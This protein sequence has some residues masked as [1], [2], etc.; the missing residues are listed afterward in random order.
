[1]YL[2]KLV[3]HRYQSTVATV[4][5]RTRAARAVDCTRPPQPGSRRRAS[6][7]APDPGS[8]LNGKITLGGYLSI[9]LLNSLLYTPSVNLSTSSDSIYF[10]DNRKIELL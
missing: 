7:A 3:S 6:C 1:M 5:P 4:P 9:F 8:L 10:L 2:L